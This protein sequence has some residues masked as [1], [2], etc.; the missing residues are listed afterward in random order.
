M[1]VNNIVSFPS[2]ADRAWKDQLAILRLKIAVQI[3]FDQWKLYRAVRIQ[4]GRGSVFTRSHDH[5]KDIRKE[6]S[7]LDREVNSFEVRMKAR[8]DQVRKEINEI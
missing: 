6:L 3:R 1:A 5:L 7:Q 4:T 8:L 2:K